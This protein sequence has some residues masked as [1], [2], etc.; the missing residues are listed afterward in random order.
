MSEISINSTPNARAQ[1]PPP[2]SGPT[3]HSP[4][5][6]SPDDVSKPAVQNQDKNLAL[7]DKS[8]RSQPSETERQTPAQNLSSVSVQFRV[9]E[10]TKEV[11]IFVIDRESKKVLRSIPSSE[12]DKMQVGDLFKLTA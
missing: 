4:H 1:E 9:D 3:R 5:S 12:L 2:V 6:D 7:Q 10:N 11:T 8:Q